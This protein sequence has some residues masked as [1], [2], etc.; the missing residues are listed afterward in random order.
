M[1]KSDNNANGIV[2]R[3]T[4]KVSTVSRKNVQRPDISAPQRQ[5]MQSRKMDSQMMQAP[6]HRQ[7]GQQ[8]QAKVVQPRIQTQ[9][10]AQMSM[11]DQMRQSVDMSKVNVAMQMRTAS[12]QAMQSRQ[13][14]EEMKSQAIA[15]ALQSASQPMKEK[16]AKSKMHFGWG[17]LMLA[18][19]C[20]VAAV[21]LIVYFV[22][23]HA[24]DISLKVAA[25]QTGIQASYPSYIPRDYNLSDITSEDKKIVL[26]FVNSSENTKY[27]LIEESSS[28]DSNALLSNYVKKEYGEDYTLV[29]ENGL[30]IYIG[31][32][33]AAWV[34]GGVLYKILDNSSSLTKKQ[35][36]SIAVSL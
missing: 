9:P 15:K 1:Q 21:F 14:A 7:N 28:W 16:K 12:Q 35:I 6:M 23:L 29:R 5:Q 31:N 33:G 26:N 18:F 24:P 11:N 17:R 32:N 25:M 34:N 10:Q 36:R 20:A 2:V 8:T 13:T 27:T 4:T 19:G 3:R 30:T 22:N